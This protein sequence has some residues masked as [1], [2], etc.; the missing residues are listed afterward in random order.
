MTETM[1]TT[2]VSGLIVVEQLPVIR[3]RLEGV[4]AAIREKVGAA[5]KM[6]CSEETVKE[7]KA[8]RASL[9]RDRA[10]MEAQRKYVK[11]AIMEPY[12]R[13]EA[14][15]KEYITS[16]YDEADK[17]LKKRIDDVEDG[18]K[19][20][21]E[22]KIRAY[23]YEVCERERIDFVPFE[24]SG[25]KITLTA[26]MKGLRTQADAFLGKIADD[27]KLIDTINDRDEVF[28]EYK[29][30]LNAS[31][32]IRAVVERHKAVEAEKKRAEEVREAFT[33]E[34]KREEE[35]SVSPALAPPVEEAYSEKKAQLTSIV[36]YMAAPEDILV[37][38]AREVKTLLINKGFIYDNEKEGFI[39]E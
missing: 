32:A 37:D 33:Q 8:L 31:E 30:S 3:E 26:S 36:L 5:L 38:A 4:S 34:G 14:I 35:K 12:E 20:E 18:L 27:L 19:R 1:T 25:L 10:E 15:Y 24:R 13:F 16:Y 2:D 29:K 11:T 28:V 17:K 22:E 6:E 9:N 39:H 23:Y 7:I 21:K